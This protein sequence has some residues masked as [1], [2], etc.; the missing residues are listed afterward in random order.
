MADDLA[1]AKF[2]GARFDAHGRCSEEREIQPKNPINS[3]F[4]RKIFVTRRP[5]RCQLN[6]RTQAFLIKVER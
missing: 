4:G 6:E 2:R 1:N 3:Y 5:V